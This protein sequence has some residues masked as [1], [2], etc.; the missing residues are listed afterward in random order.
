M[1]G[2]KQTFMFHIPHNVKTHIQA[3]GARAHQQGMHQSRGNIRSENN[4]LRHVAVNQADEPGAT[5]AAAIS[6][7]LDKVT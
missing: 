1:F 4:I 6:R 3:A 2:L 5:E 7:V